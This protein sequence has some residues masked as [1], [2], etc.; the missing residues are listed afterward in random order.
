[1]VKDKISLIAAAAGGFMLFV[2]ISGILQGVPVTVLRSQHSFDSTQVANFRL[3]EVY[4][5]KSIND[6]FW[7]TDN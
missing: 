6:S 3:Q 7:S 2:A 4:S 1:M 5:D